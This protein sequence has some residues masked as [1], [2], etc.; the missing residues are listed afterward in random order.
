[1]EGML[2]KGKEEKQAE[3]VQFAEYKMFCENTAKYKTA[4]IA[5]ANEKI[6]LLKADIEKLSTDAAHLGTQVAAL[7]EDIA[8]W[9]GDMKAATKVREIEKAE[10]DAMHLDYSQSIEALQGAIKVLK[11]Q[12]YDRTQA[13]ASLA[14]VSELRRLK[15]MPQAKRII[16]SFLSQ[17]DTES[18]RQPADEGLA[19]SAPEA[20]GYDFQSGQIITTLEKLLDEFI[21]ERTNLEK[22]ES[23]S[24]HEHEMLMQDLEHQTSEATADRTEK[25]E[26]KAK[27]LQA[28]ADAEGD[29]TDTTTTRDEDQRYLDDLVATCEQKATDYQ[30]RQEL[31]VQEMTAIGQAIEIISSGAV[32]GSA[33]KHLPTLLQQGRALASLRVRDFRPSQEQV[34]A[35]LQQKARALGSRVLAAL[36]TRVLAD[37]FGKVKKMI[38]DLIMRLMEEAAEETEHKGWCDTELS[39]NEQTR[40]E[41]TLAVETLTAEIDELGA[42][43]GVLGEDIAELAKAVA[44]LDTAMAEATKVRGEEKATNAETISDAKEAQTAVAQALTVLREFYAKAAEATALLQQ[45]AHRDAQAPEIFDSPYQGMAAESGGVVGMLEVIEADFGR[46][47]ADTAASEAT[48]Q[49]EYE[50]FMEDSKI[51]YA[52]KSKDIEHKSAKKKEEE[53]AL[54]V[55]SVDLEGTQKEMTAAI[56]YY[57]KLKP[58]CVDA[59]VSYEDRVARRKEEIESLQQ[60][61]RILNGEDIPR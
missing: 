26:L 9:A 34:S 56:A 3:T 6:E 37:P 33:E 58:D 10:Y 13:A 55:K 47:E 23:D 46:L 49:K 35:F 12:D 1:M 53:N 4:A 57:D 36:A 29:L 31:R 22:E 42:S 21:A 8:V 5:E 27:K 25:A 2:S 18:D 32:A 61:L 52:G 15:Q 60:A 20:H 43:I 7:D 17:E 45:R 41:K 30:A 16:D 40:K 48:A 38:K 28:K 50:K 39:T 11:K 44:E 24:K 54:H 14:Q 51:D 59:G 19:V